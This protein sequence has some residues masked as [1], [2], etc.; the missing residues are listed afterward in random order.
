M[1]REIKFRGKRIDNDQ[2]IYGCL[3]NN[4]WA[5]SELSQF[6]KGTKVCE[7]FTGEYSSDNWLDA[8]EED[9]FIFQVYPESVGQYTGLKDKNGVEIYEGDIFKMG[10]KKP[11]A[12]IDYDYCGFVIR[13]I[14]KT[15][16]QVREFEKEPIFRNI[17]L[18]EVIGNIHENPEL[19]NQPKVN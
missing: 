17:N 16:L 2:I 8:I 10:S 19:L 15:Y 4:M 11:V 5:Y 7:I 3:V 1:S 6:E 13:W 14:D 9:N 18:F 12:I